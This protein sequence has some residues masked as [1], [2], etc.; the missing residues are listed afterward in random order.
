M[1][2]SLRIMPILNIIETS[3]K[4][5]EPIVEFS[6]AALQEVLASAHE[7]KRTTYDSIQLSSRSLLVTEAVLLMRNKAIEIVKNMLLDARTEVRLAG[8][9]VAEDIG[10]CHSGPGISSDIPLKEKIVKDRQEILDFIDKNGLIGKETD[11]H[12]LSSYEDLLFNGWARQ[13][14]PDEKSLTLLNQFI[15]DPEYRIIRYYTSRWDITGDV[16]NKLKDAPVKERWSWVVNNIMPRKWHLTVDDFEKD[17]IALNKKYPSSGDITNFLDWIGKTV[18]VSSANASFLRAW[19]KQNPEAFKQIRNQKE[20]WAKIPLIFKY[21]ITYDLVQKYPEVAKAIIDEV[22]L[23]PNIPTDE[24][25]IA[26]DIL[27]CDIPSLD[28]LG[29]IKAV[30]EKNIDDL[31]ITI[32]ERIRF[33]GDK[34]SAKSMA[35]I[36]LIVLNHLSTQAQAK[37]AVHIAFILHNKSKEYVSDFLGVTRDV[38]YST[39][40]HDSKLDYHDFEI[41]TL[42]FAD[43]KELLSFIEDRLEREKEI[44]K[45][46]EYEAIPFQGIEFINKFI[47]TNANYSFAI[48]KVIEWDKKHEGTY[49][50]SKIFE[51]FIS[52]RNA[53]DLL[54]FDYIKAEFYNKDGF[55][56][57]LQC[58]FG[59]PLTRGNIDTFKEIVVKSSELGYE[60]E[61]IKLLRSKIYPRGSWS[62][63]IGQIP[64]VFIEKKECFEEL[65]K[66]APAGKLRN[67]LDECVRGAEK[68]IEEH[69]KEEENRFFSR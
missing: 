14:V 61:M 16:R 3:F 24:A 69:K 42:L 4:G 7:C 9:D 2:L 31:N 56:K 59:L 33:I 48:R 22:L 23:I 6:K 1:F 15:Y 63:S 66:I 41:A 25:K 37:A 43:V 44:N 13:N 17:A 46:S 5:S 62:S 47:N 35:E 20:L 19:F 38:L 11:R 68:I 12:V 34:I 60:D 28:K 64:P 39:L 26:I 32:L 36:V 21:T 50:V 55:S 10:R 51:Q 67:T 49:S 45:H 27:S 54:Y 58:L 57:C 29:I 8:I 52:L 40:L 18:T 30:A 65:K 53:S